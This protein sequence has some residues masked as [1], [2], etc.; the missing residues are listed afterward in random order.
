MSNT[1]SYE[2][3]K[4]MRNN[5]NP[6]HH[7][8]IGSFSQ[9]RVEFSSIDW[10]AIDDSSRRVYSGYEVIECRANSIESFLLA[11]FEDY[12]FGFVVEE[13][14]STGL[15]FFFGGSVLLNSEH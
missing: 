11:N 4:N 10:P 15:S 8:N 7:L 1:C 5:G 14:C 12:L 2:R 9:V 3:F 6:V 13:Q